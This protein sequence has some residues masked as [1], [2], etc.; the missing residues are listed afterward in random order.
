MMEQMLFPL[1][2]AQQNI[3]AQELVASGTDVNVLYFVLKAGEPLR[4]DCLEQAVN[5]FL[6]EN[7]GARTQLTERDGS[8][9]QYIAPYAEQPL[10]TEDLRS[11]RREEQEESFRR[12]GHRPFRLLDA[13]LVEFRH[14]LLSD[15]MDGLF[16]K[17]HHIW[18][19]GWATG[20]LWSEIFTNYLE[21]RDGK[22]PEHHHP[23]PVDFLPQEQEYA[24]SAQEQEDRAFWQETLRDLSLGESYLT[25]DMTAVSLL[26]L[27]LFDIHHPVKITL[28][29]RSPSAV[30]CVPIIKE[31]GA[32]S[33]LPP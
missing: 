15:T 21:I 3:E 32:K 16:C 31:N 2:Y 7:P 20:L 26:P 9:M 10:R 13:P 30:F 4:H 25:P 24:G 17:F 11:L 18:C 27:L 5:L 19:D 14:V 33:N 23:S 8:Y 28:H 6:R 22:T 29:L 12:W 1:S